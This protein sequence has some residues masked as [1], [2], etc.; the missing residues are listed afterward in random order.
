MRGQT[1]LPDEKMS[2]PLQVET[3]QAALSQDVASQSGTRF[4][5]TGLGLAGLVLLGVSAY[6]LHPLASRARVEPAGLVPD[7]AFSPMPVLS[8]RGIRPASRGGGHIRSTASRPADPPDL[9]RRSVIAQVAGPALGIPL[10]AYG[11]DRIFEIPEKRLFTL[12]LRLIILRLY[13]AENRSTLPRDVVKHT[14]DIITQVA[15]EL[16]A[17]QTSKS[18]KKLIED[19]DDFMI[20]RLGLDCT[21]PELLE[22]SLAAICTLPSF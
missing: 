22:P 5:W 20:E 3:D 9:S 4:L 21:S 19:L 13:L 16:K 15:A 2:L 6:A 12:Q 8:P 17:D 1:C 11:L 18:V 10:V 7:L 14:A